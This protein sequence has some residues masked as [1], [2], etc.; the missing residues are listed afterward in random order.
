MKMRFKRK[1]IARGVII[2]LAA[3]FVCGMILLINSWITKQDQLFQIRYGVEISNEHKEIF[4]ITNRGWWS[5]GFSYTVYQA[6]PEDTTLRD[7]F[8]PGRDKDVETLAKRAA[9]YLQIT[10][11]HRIHFTDD[12]SYRVIR[13]KSHF[14]NYLLIL[15]ENNSNKYYFIEKFAGSDAPNQSGELLDYMP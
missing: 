11:D 6:D 3:A 15:H 1:M 4:S 13:D 2:L 10:K 14:N 7:D 9:E 8:N 5:E 12:Y